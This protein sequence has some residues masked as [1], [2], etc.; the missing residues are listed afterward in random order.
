MK[1]EF[2]NIQEW[3]KRFKPIASLET[4]GEEYRCMQFIEAL[5]PGCV[6]T[7]CQ[8]D[9]GIYINAGWHF[10][11]RIVYWVTEIPSESD[12][13]YQVAYHGDS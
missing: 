11:N 7:E 5:F 3:E 2:M 6:W 12:T 10:V 13:F 1:S 4:L 9:E 8:H